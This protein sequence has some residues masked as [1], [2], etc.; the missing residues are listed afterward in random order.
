MLDEYAKKLIV[1]A[2][3]D[4]S[5]RASHLYV[6]ETCGKLY[7]DHPVYKDVLQFYPELILHLVCNGN[8]VK[9]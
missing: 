3:I 4:R 1:D 5:Y 6:C 2:M 9:L 8:L 7:A